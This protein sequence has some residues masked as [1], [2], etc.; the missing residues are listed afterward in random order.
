MS[1]LD[2]VEND[3]ITIIFPSLSADEKELNPKQ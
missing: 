2:N 3:P 1:N